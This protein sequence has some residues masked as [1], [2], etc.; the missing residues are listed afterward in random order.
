M[1]YNCD[2]CP[3]SE[4]C[5][6]EECSDNRSVINEI[7][8]PEDKACLYLLGRICIHSECGYIPDYVVEKLMGDA[9]YS[10]NHMG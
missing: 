2:T 10:C 6:R 1:K 9:E 8:F 7:E 5:D 3:S 4:W